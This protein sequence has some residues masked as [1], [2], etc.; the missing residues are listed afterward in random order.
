[1]SSASG[2][3]RVFRGGSWFF[4]PQIARVAFRGNFTPGYRYRSL[5][6]RLMRRCT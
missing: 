6:V 3:H 1:M 5:G 2:Y 4:D